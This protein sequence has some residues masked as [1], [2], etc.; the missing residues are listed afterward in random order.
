MTEQ[1]GATLPSFTDAAGRTFRYTWPK[2]R[3]AFAA[4]LTVLG[5]CLCI[6]GLAL[7]SM[8]AGIT[9]L[10]CFLPGAFA[11]SVYYQIYRGSIGEGPRLA[12]FMDLDEVSAS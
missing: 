5:I 10:I 6:S 9:G 1:R 12:Q 8:A 11:L 7:T 2:Y 3:I 4:L